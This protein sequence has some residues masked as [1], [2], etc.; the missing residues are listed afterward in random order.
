MVRYDPRIHNAETIRPTQLARKTDELALAE[1][2][3]IGAAPSA[4]DEARPNKQ[5]GDDQASQSGSESEAAS[6]TPATNTKPENP[7]S[8]EAFAELRHNWRHLMYGTAEPETKHK[9]EVTGFSF[10]FSGLPEAPPKP[11]PSALVTP[12]TPTQNTFSLKAQFSTAIAPSAA[13]AVPE[14]RS[15]PVPGS[16]RKPAGAGIATTPGKK[17]T[18]SAPA[19]KSKRPIDAA[20]V[21]GASFFATSS[22]LE[23]WSAKK[24]KLSTD[25]RRKSKAARVRGKVGK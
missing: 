6:E 15:N 2:D 24:Q 22:G 23:N 5:D 13:A 11:A 4:A 19:K 16:H 9:P 21:T 10:G 17:M 14:E 1:P 20:S 25:Y 3:I 8:Q 7:A 12:A 18:W